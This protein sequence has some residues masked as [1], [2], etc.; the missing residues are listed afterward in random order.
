MHIRHLQLASRDR[1]A[2]AEFYLQTLGLPGVIGKHDFTC[3]VGSSTLSFIEAGG[4]EPIHYHFAFNIPSLQLNDAKRWLAKRVP[5]VKDASGADKFHFDDWNAD[6]VYFYDPAG[7]L[8]ELIARQGLIAP[9]VKPFSSA[10]LLGIS[11][12][13]IVTDDVIGTVKQFQTHTGS[14]VYGGTL[15]E[16]FTPIGDEHG[17]L[18]VV[19]RGRLW[20]PDV[21]LAAAPAPI[22]AEIESEN[23]ERI[24]FALPA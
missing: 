3:T 6:A 20:Y 21:R 15:D 13:G 17:L 23:G 16:G 2:L 19:K 8:V 1:S 14:P 11:E 4:H 12:I 24:H 7:N 22:R 9:S 10:A 18:I 5:L